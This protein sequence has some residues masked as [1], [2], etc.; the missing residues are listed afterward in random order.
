MTR[1]VL[2]I[3]S[4][5]LDDDDDRTPAQVRDEVRLALPDASVDLPG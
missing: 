2:L 4:V 1:T 5:D 3:V